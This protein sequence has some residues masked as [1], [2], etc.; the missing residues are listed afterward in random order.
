MHRTIAFVL[1]LLVLS[2]G[3]AVTETYYVAP[4]GTAATVAADGSEAR[5]FVGLLAAFGSGKI[6]GGDTLLLKDG[7][8]GAIDLKTNVT[9][10]KPVVI[11]SQTGKNAHFDWI[12]LAGE[13]RFITLK[14]LRVWPR[15]PEKGRNYLVRAYTTTSDIT[16]D[17]LVIRGEQNAAR[18]MEWDAAKWNARKYSGILLQ[19]NRST[20]VRN[21]LTGVH[22]GISIASGQ[23]VNNLV[24][25]YSGDGL[26]AFSDAVVKRNRVLNCVQVD[27]NHADGFQSFSGGEP[28]KNL[29]IESNV[30][31]EWT[32]DAKHP[33]RCS[34]QGIGLFDGFYDNVKIFNN[35]IAVSAYHGIA[36]YGARGGLIANN[37]VVNAR[38]LTSQEPWIGVFNLKSGT[39][40][41]DVVVAN[42]AAMRYMGGASLANRVQFRS[43]SVIGT[44]SLVFENPAAFDYRPRA[45][46][47]LLNSADKAVAP[48]RDMLNQPR[49]SG[50]GPDRGSYEVQVGGASASTSALVKDTNDG[51]TD[52]TGTATGTTTGVYTTVAKWIRLPWA[53]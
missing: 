31:I 8:Y 51:A 41:T 19:G 13:A 28:V 49:P 43:N 38:G 47:N 32:G 9:F 42:N 26:R 17:G 30:I 16:V 21:R 40:S 53:K 45:N 36:V 23:V 20:V 33:L 44:P 1:G 34:L 35:L 24:N 10:D 4:P 48:P 2:S 6:K 5:P 11:Q 29:T 14:N 39:P 22:F 25:G 3:P 52:N 15:D 46:S 37:T 50:S 12:Q 18:F 27:D 7:V